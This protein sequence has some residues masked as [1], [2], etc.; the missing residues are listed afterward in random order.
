MKKNLLSILILVLLV[1]NIALTAVMM[2]SVT[3]TNKK[4]AD[5]ITSIATVMNLELY[6]PGGEPVAD[7]PLSET[8]TFD[9]TGTLTIPLTVES[10]VD[11]NGVAQVGKQTYIQFAMTLFMNMGHEDYKT[12]GE[13]IA[14]RQSAILDTVTS[15]VSAYTE[16]EC[17]A[18]ID[19]MRQ[20]I[21]DAIQDLFQSDFIY[22]IGINNIKYG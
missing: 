15:V 22:K 11:S 16:N 5:L 20:E 12:Y 4:T 17:R 6:E 7:I 21:L 8:A 19:A 10:T 18:D 13:S 3:G 9:L 2:I 1:V 14:D